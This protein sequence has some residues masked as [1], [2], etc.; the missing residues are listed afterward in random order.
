MEHFN[1]NFN[2]NRSSD[3]LP[4]FSDRV[5]PSQFHD[6]SR[7]TAPPWT[8]IDGDGTDVPVFDNEIPNDD[9]TYGVRQMQ[10]TNLEARSPSD[11]SVSSVHRKTRIKSLLWPVLVITLPMAL[12]SAALLGLVFGYRVRSQPDVFA[13]DV[14]GYQD[15]HSSY[16]LVNYPATR[17]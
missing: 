3:G 10:D 16:V 7:Y 8:G 14:G 12:L 9:R 1:F 6:R 4:S 5:V 13:S 2:F 15:L 11:R 17:L